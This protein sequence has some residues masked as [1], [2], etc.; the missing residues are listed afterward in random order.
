[1][2]QLAYQADLLYIIQICLTD[3]NIQ[4][5][6]KTKKFLTFKASLN[7]IDFNGSE[8]TF[9]LDGLPDLTVRFK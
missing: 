1:M 6:T 5:V 3:I 4:F 9:R 7:S 8:I 2:A